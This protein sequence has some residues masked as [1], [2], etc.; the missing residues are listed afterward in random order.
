M[1]R[2][3]S[4]PMR[5]SPKAETGVIGTIIAIGT[6]LL[7]LPVLPFI[8]ALWAIDRIRGGDRAERAMERFDTGS[9]AESPSAE[10]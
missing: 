10:R 5:P 6:L 1:T 4:R 2:S 3:V 7:L 8:A 9:S